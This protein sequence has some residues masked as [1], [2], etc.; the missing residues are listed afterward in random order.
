LALA[1][2]F[3][4]ML[5]PPQGMVDVLRYHGERGLQIE[6]TWGV[7]LA[8]WRVATGTAAPTR[9]TFGSYNL[10]GGAAPVLAH[11]AMVAT[12]AAL[13]ALVVVLARS[14]RPRDETARR[15]RITLTLLAS[16]AIL[17]LTS[18]VFSPQYLTW[19]LPIVLAVSPPLGRRLTWLLVAA[20]AVTQAYIR[21][22]YDYVTDLHPLGVGTLLVRLAIL[23]SFAG[24]L[25]RGLRTGSPREAVA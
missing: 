14:P 9:Q 19:A 7:I 2:A 13:G 11:L 1:L 25:A 3:A 16:L 15:D 18:K 17:W 6:S 10:E 21:G 12:L 8:A 5:F 20:M 24:L 4:P 23:A 22:Y